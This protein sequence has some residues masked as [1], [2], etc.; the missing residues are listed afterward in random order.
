LYKKSY[1][2]LH[3]D[4]Y[5]RCLESDEAKRVMQK[6]YDE[7]CGNHVGGRSFAHKVI[8]QG[9]Y[10]P[11]MFDDAK[12]YVKKCLQYQRLALSSNIPNEDHTLRSP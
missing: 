11:K 1:S 4:P 7:D 5:L 10:W 8:N 6:I 3:S 2:K 9:C 12:E